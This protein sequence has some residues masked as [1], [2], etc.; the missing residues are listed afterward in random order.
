M[1]TSTFCHLKGLTQRSEEK[2]WSSGIL[3]WSH[4]ERCGKPVFSPKKTVSVGAQMEESRRALAEL[5]AWH[6]LERLPAAELPRVYPHL[7]GRIGYLDIETT[8]LGGSSAVTTIALYDGT[9]VRTFVRGENLDEFPKAVSAYS[10]IVTYNGG[11]FD[12]PFLRNEFGLRFDVAHLDLMRTL[13]ARGYTGG[14]KRCEK[15]LGI[16][17]QLPEDM[18][19][20]EA[21]RLWYAH[22]A[23]DP[24]AL[25]KLLA[26]NA[27]DV[28][29]LELLL[30]KMYNLSMSRYPLFRETPLPKQ[31]R[32]KWPA[33]DHGA[34]WRNCMTYDPW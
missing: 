25:P 23:G 3:T 34:G 20:F 15:L 10:L 17:R 5:N 11:R 6:F 30:V 26:Y 9:E 1:L 18:D 24:V 33:D 2:L 4:Y 13:R 31:L 12:L 27:Q 16:R 29:S 22:R 19:G 28:L 21:V 14:L 7:A 8:G 32:I